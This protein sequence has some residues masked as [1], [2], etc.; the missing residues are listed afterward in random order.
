MYS[1][2]GWKLVSSGD[3]AIVSYFFEVIKMITVKK[4]NFIEKIGSNMKVINTAPFLVGCV[5][6]AGI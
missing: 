1:F 6:Q 5:L 4:L 3:R 2:T